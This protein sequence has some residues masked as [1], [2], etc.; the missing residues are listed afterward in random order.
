MDILRGIYPD[1]KIEGII[2]YIDLGKIVRI[3]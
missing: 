2:T 1:K 3:R